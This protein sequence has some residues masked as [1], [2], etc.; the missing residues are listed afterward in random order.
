MCKQLELMYSVRMEEF[1]NRVNELAALEE[2]LGEEVSEIMLAHREKENL[3]T[4]KQIGSSVK[5]N[6][7]QGLLDSLWKGCSDIGMEFTYKRIGKETHMNVSHCPLAE[8]AI[9][10]DKADWG[11]KCYCMDDEAIVKGF[12]SEIE[13]RRSKTL[14]EGDDCC[15]HIYIEK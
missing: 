1:K 13:F 10:I 6:N 2:K 12:N 8:M 14:M 5:E 15:D 4:W 9:E 11:F 7:V 3:K